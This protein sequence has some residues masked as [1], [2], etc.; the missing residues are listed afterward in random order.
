MKSSL[1]FERYAWPERLF[2]DYHP[3]A[4]IIIV[5]PAF[6]EPHLIDALDSLNACTPPT[7]KVLIMVI[8]NEPEQVEAHVSDRNLA[9]IQKLNEYDSSYSLIYTHLRL[10]QKKAGVGLARK[11]SMDEAAALFHLQGKDGIIVCYDADCT[12]DR[13]YLIEIEKK[14]A[15]KNAGIVFYEHRTD[16]A[17]EQEIIN[18][19]LYLRYYI[20]GLRVA[21]FPYAHQTLGSCIV[22][23]SS[24]YQKVG[25]M[26]TRKAG[27]DFYFLNKVIPQGGFTEINS[28]TIRP[29]GRIS[30]RVPFGT[31]RAV[32][33]LTRSRDTFQV[34]NP[35]VFSDIKHV[36][37]QMNSV[38][39]GYYHHLPETFLQFL[40]D[41][42][43][44][45]L[46]QLTASVSTPENF[47]RRFFDWLDAFRILKYVHFLRDHCYPN[48]P[49]DMAIGWIFS[50][51][52]MQHTSDQLV[53]LSRLRALDRSYKVE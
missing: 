49:L 48:V 44:D 53:Q 15:G 40:G 50:T 12:C 7:G 19:E 11:I 33:D 1:Y 37:D 10:P 25:G 18:Y 2:P 24:L 20:D 16:G 4:D 39:K 17:Y 32:G 38:W 6:K 41:S 5:V 36:I 23:K 52:G 30:D 3:E 21:G 8:V 22:V 43:E 13:D 42:Y 51:L 45:D 47:H 14:L 29:S 31:G 35:L 9:T 26:N 28:T 34:Y 27:E 46:S